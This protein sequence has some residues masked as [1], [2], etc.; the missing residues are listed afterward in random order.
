MY[1]SERKLC[2]CSFSGAETQVGVFSDVA[3]VVEIFNT[4]NG[5][6]VVLKKLTSGVVTVVVSGLA[7]VVVVVVPGLNRL[8]KKGS[9]DSA[10]FREFLS[11]QSTLTKLEGLKVKLKPTL[12]KEASRPNKRKILIAVL[13]SSKIETTLFKCQNVNEDFM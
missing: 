5:S 8:L 6:T 4:C 2:T 7:V 13:V 12:M 3:G 1:S 10:W 9:C 11:V